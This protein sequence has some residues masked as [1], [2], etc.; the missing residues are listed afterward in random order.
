MAEGSLRTQD[1]KTWA[2]LAHATIL[3]GWT[4]GLAT[5]GL[6]GPAAAFVVW[7]IKKE[8][9]AYVGDQA[10]QSLV[11]QSV[12]VIFS[13]LMWAVI[14]A[15]SAIVVGLCLIPF[16]ILLNLGA[17]IYGCY[18]AY[19]CSQGRDFRYVIIGDVVRR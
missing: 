19:V 11:Y 8:E 7:L 10:L 17:V 12:V 13:W 16:G 2:A 6:L 9:S 1:E 15:L 5:A 4:V 3:L 18:A 14:A